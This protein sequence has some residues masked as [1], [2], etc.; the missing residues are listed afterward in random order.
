MELTEEEIYYRTSGKKDIQSSSAYE[1]RTDIK[2]DRKRTAMNVNI[3]NF[4]QLTIQQLY[5]LMRR[6]FEVFVIEQQCEEQDFDNL[7][8][9]AIH[10]FVC[11]EGANVYAYCRILPAETK[12]KEASIGRVLVT[13][14]YRKQGIATALLKGAIAHIEEELKENKIKVQAQAHLQNFYE[15]LGF[16][17]ISDVFDE[18][19]I[20]HIKMIRTCDSKHGSE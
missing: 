18:G 12:Y 1:Y 7:D 9:E 17:R 4:E 6:R 3:R 2:R 16:K 8:Q 14:A 5:E 11:D 10:L 20:P 19:G 13:K 15:A